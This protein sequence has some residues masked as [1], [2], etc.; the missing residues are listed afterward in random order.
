MHYDAAMRTLQ[1]RNLPDHVYEALALRAEREGRSLAQQA[2]HE[3]GKMPEVEARARRRRAVAEL[4]EGYR[5]DG[6]R[7]LNR[8]PVA[9]VREDRE[10]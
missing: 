6:A 1:I 8:S 5:R 7:R 3:L 2:V 9:L 10:R 4:A